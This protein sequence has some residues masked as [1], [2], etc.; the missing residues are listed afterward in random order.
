MGAGAACGGGS[1]SVDAGNDLATTACPDSIN[2]VDDG[3]ACGSVD[4][5]CNPCGKTCGACEE[6]LCENGQ[7]VHMLLQNTCEDAGS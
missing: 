5:Q 4:L 1:S 7:W 6:L 2:D 3:Q